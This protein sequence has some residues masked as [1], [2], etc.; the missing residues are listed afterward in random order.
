M[1]YHTYGYGNTFDN[2]IDFLYNMVHFILIIKVYDSHFDYQT[3]W[4][5]F[6]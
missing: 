1:T 5:Q 4:Q 6:T 2:F 3:I